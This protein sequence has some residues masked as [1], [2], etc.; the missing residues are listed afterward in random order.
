MRRPRVSMRHI[1]FA[2]AA[3]AALLGIY[4]HLVRESLWPG[5][6]FVGSDGSHWYRKMTDKE[7]AEFDWTLHRSAI[8]GQNG[9]A[10]EAESPG[11]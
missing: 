6:G 4:M 8:K 2:I 11:R 7:I 10:R 1:M 5:I 3:I 9:T